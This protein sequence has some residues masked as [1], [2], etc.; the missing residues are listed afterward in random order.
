MVPIAI[1]N[2]AARELLY[3]K[4]TTQLRA[5]Q[6]STASGAM[7]SGVYIWV[8]IRYLRPE[9]AR[10]AINTGLLWLV[11]AVAFEF[12]FGRFVAGHSWT[13]LFRHCNIFAS[14]LWAPLLVWITPAPTPFYRL[15]ASLR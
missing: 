13:R 12:I 3:G 7:P 1:L 8:V 9:S 14:Q 15:T 5:H 2:G 6:I 11:L 10:Q 4:N